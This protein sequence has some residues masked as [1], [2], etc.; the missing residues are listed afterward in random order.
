VSGVGGQAGGVAVEAENGDSPANKPWIQSKNLVCKLHAKLQCYFSQ[1]EESYCLQSERKFTRNRIQIEFEEISRI[2]ERNNFTRLEI[3]VR[4]SRYQTLH[5]I[6][7]LN[8]Q[9]QVFVQH[10]H[11][12]VLKSRLSISVRHQE[13]FF[14]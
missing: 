1:Y 13:P 7:W 14:D 12:Q 11:F 10:S 6:V 9:T 4:M 8:F 2:F 3:S 5:N